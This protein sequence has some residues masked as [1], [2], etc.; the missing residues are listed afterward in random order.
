MRTVS[1][2]AATLWL[3]LATEHPVTVATTSAATTG[4]AVVL[5]K[6]VVLLSPASV[7]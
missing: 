1:G 2:R 5:F 7:V 6:I 4:H 3:E